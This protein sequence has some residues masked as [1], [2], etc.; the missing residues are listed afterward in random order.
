MFSRKA[1]YVTQADRSNSIFDSSRTNSCVVCMG[2]HELS[3]CDRFKQLSQPERYKLVQEHRLCRN[4]LLLDHHV[5]DCNSA[6]AYT[7]C[8]MNYLLHIDGGP[9]KGRHDVKKAENI[10]TVNIYASFAE[11]SKIPIRL[12]RVLPIIPVMA[13][14]QDG[15]HQVLTYALLDSGSTNTFCSVELANELHWTGRHASI[16]VSTVDQVKTPV[17][18][19]KL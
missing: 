10:N 18:V 3:K 2:K 7:K 16:P 19:K 14:S 11:H 5:K 9:P 1:S 12:H 6:V 15:R 13:K 17:H 8:K 4:C